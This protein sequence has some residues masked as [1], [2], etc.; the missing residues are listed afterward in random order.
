MAA[1]AVFGF[2][3]LICLGSATHPA[4]GLD[5]DAAP[6]L[7]DL[8]LLAIDAI[9]LLLI[10]LLLHRLRHLADADAVAQLADRMMVEVERMQ[11]R[12]TERTCGAAKRLIGGN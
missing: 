10:A 1:V 8:L 11:R 7:W 3:A 9:E 5:L 4:T 2:W 12:C 6:T